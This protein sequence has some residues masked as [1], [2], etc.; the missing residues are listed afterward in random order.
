MVW[1]FLNR[2]IPGIVIAAKAHFL[3]SRGQKFWAESRKK[4]LKIRTCDNFD[5]KKLL[6]SE[7]RE[8][9][10]TTDKLSNNTQH[11]VVI[12]ELRVKI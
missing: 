4:V 2:S 12:N 7:Q 11:P 3:Q 6:S 1:S 5:T 8:K 10:K 9:T